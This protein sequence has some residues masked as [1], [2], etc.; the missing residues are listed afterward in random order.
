MLS[1]R[2]PPRLPI[3]APGMF[4]KTRQ[5]SRLSYLQIHQPNPLNIRFGQQ[6]SAEIFVAAAQDGIKEDI[7]AM[8]A[9]GEVAD[10]NVPNKHGTTALIAAARNGHLHIVEYLANKEK[11]PDIDLDAQD[12]WGDTALIDATRQKHKDIVKV[13]LDA[14]ATVKKLWNSNKMNALDVAALTGDKELF[15]LILN[16]VKPSERAKD[17]DRAL[18][19]SSPTITDTI[20]KATV[21]FKDAIGDML[22]K[23]NNAYTSL[24]GNSSG[25]AHKRPRQKGNCRKTPPKNE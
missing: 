21:A 14:G 11:F 10:I 5:D 18:G 3:T 7:D 15:E 1:S 16:Y 4:D 8:L 12:K 24:R 22:A 2:I 6:S 17:S 20:S 9:S 19:E 23:L 25:S 13:L